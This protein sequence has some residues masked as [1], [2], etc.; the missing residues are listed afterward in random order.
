MAVF[1]SVCLCLFCPKLPLLSFLKIL[2]AALESTLIQHDLVLNWLHLEDITLPTKARIVKAMVFLVVIYR[3]ESWT[4][5]KAEHWRIDA[6]KL[7]CWWRLLTVPWTTRRSNQSILK[8]INP[9]Y[10]QEGL[11]L[12]LK[13]QYFDYLMWRADS[14]K[15]P[16]LPGKLKAKGKGSCRGWHGW[17]ASSTQWTWVW[18]NSGRWWGIGKPG[19][20]QSMGSRRVGH[21]LVTE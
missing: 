10:S 6:F 2:A 9:E 15:K 19:M 21:G 8:E 18:A 16:L 13:L 5:K 7:W 20:L 12:N 14:M 3:C 4:I 11:M 1:P 17:M